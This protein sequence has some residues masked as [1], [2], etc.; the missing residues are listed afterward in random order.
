[1][2]EKF[3]NEKKKIIS[4]RNLNSIKIANKKMITTTKTKYFLPY[5]GFFTSRQIETVYKNNKKNIIS[6]YQDMCKKN[7]TILLDVDVKQ[8]FYF[9]RK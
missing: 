2:F 5:A 6:D 9:S 4:Q 3:S 8:K 1:M 7:N